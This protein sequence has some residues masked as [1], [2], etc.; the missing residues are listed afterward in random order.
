LEQIGSV[1]A[2]VGCQ[3]QSQIL[4]R[5]A[6]EVLR[7]RQQRVLLPLDELSTAPTEPGVFLLAYLVERFIQV[8]E[9]MELVEQ[10]RRLGS[11]APGR[12]AKRFPHVHHG[13]ADSFRLP[14]PEKSIELVHAR[15]AAISAA[16]PDRAM[17]LQIADHDA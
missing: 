14:F 17:P 4:A 8:P 11:M 12:V 2:L 6:T 9:D 1:Q 3:Q 16:E 5:L 15:F 10:D 13:H 7:M